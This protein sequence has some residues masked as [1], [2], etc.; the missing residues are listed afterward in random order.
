MA[1]LYIAVIISGERQKR[2][3]NVQHTKRLSSESTQV[4]NVTVR[5][6]INI[7]LVKYWGKSD[8]AQ[9]LPL[10]DSLSVTIDELCA[11]TSVSIEQCTKTPVDRVT[12]NNKVRGACE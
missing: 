8:E 11:T 7:A 1:T 4:Q 3:T 12:I 6:P 2:S 9:M 10:N 5:V